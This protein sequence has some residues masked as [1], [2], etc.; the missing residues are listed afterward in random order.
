[1][2]ISTGVEESGDDCKVWAGSICVFGGR[3]IAVLELS[4]AAGAPA[5]AIP[6]RR[7]ERLL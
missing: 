7:G 6:V 1:M 4:I 2:V 3:S 5:E